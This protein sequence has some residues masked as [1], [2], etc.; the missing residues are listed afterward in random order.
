MQF[1][2]P[3]EQGR[4]RKR[5]KRFLADIETASGEQLTIHC[6]GGRTFTADISSNGALV[7]IGTRTVALKPRK[8]S[9]GRRFETKGAAL[10]IDGELVALV[11][12][13]DIDYRN[14]RL[15]GVGSQVRNAR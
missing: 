9:L 2:P 6:D 13:D 15:N 8:S 5:Y 4:L 7:T 1:D 10:I 14:C 12:N 11:F 3:L